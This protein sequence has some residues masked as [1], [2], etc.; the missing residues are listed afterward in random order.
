MSE[1]VANKANRYALYP[2]LFFVFYSPTIRANKTT[3]SPT[4]SHA[5]LQYVDVYMDD[6][7][8]ADQGYPSQKQRVSELTNRA[9]KYT[10]PSLPYKVN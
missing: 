1:T 3:K 4:A 6:L 8:C 9:L 7:L 5:H 2:S 10:P